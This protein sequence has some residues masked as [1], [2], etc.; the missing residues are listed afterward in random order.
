[1]RNPPFELSIF[2]IVSP[3]NRITISEVSL[4][5]PNV[6]KT[7]YNKLVRDFIPDI[8][9]EN[10]DSADFVTLDSRKEFLAALLAK[11]LE[12]SD[13]V[14]GAVE[15]EDPAEIAKE[16]ADVREVLD[17]IADEFAIPKDEIEC[18]QQERRRKRGAFVRRLFLKSTQ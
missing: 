1:M 17:A 4:T 2:F 12:E 13:E 14:R 9:A 8:I 10:G 18:V 11:I 3:N 5:S 16:I 6:P 7:V 15:T